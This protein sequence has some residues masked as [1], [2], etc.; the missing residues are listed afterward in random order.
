MGI[1]EANKIR[2][3]G[4]HFHSVHGYLGVATTV[5]LLVQYLVGFLMYGV[6]AVFDGLDGGAKSLY[7][8][9]RWGGYTI[10]V[11]LLATTAS[12]TWTEYNEFVLNIK[13]WTV[14]VA[15]VFIVVGVYP[16]ISTTKLGLNRSG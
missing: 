1:I 12:A 3:H 7:K 2:S 14:L 8:Y 13:P 9:H 10:F 16:R 15:I 6:P 11:L 5:L 4:E